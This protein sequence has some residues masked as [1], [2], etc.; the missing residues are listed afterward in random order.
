MSAG[1]SSLIP[2]WSLATRRKRLNHW[3]R[4]SFSDRLD[5][6]GSGWIPDLTRC[7]PIQGFRILSGV[8]ECL[9]HEDQSSLNFKL[10]S[11]SQWGR[12]ITVF[13]VSRWKCSAKRREDCIELSMSAD[14]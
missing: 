11:F 10:S 3:S 1:S 14:G 9:E 4:G 12:T 8:S 2:M 13:V 5:C 7:T 6:H